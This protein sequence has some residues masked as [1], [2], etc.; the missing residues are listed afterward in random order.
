MI[1]AGHQGWARVV[2]NPVI[3][4][5]LRTHFDHFYATGLPPSIP[6]DEGLLIIPNHF[7][8]WDGFFIFQLMCQMKNRRLH[9]MMLE[10]QLSRYWYFRHIGAY[11]INPGHPKSVMESL[12]YTSGLLDDPARLVVIYPQGEIETYNKRPLTLEPGILLALKKTSRE[13]NVLPVFFRIEYFERRKPDIWFGYGRP[14]KKA[15]VISDFDGFC[16]TFNNGIEEF[17]RKV[18]SREFMTDCFRNKNAGEWKL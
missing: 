17:D 9:L 7:S 14:E 1:K 13:V 12:R 5:L 15:D 3:K 18:D 16:R 8:W 11:S 10:K 6:A 4:G 2:F